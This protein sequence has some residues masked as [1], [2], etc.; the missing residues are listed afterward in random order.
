M[1]VRITMPTKDGKRLR[2]QVIEGA[3]QVEDD[4][5]G[6]NE[7]EAVSTAFYFFFASAI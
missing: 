4:E 1:R 5:M 2:E 7:W 3:E 6:Q